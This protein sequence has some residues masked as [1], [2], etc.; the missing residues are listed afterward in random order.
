MAWWAGVPQRT[1]GGQ[2]LCTERPPVLWRHSFGRSTGLVQ[3][4]MRIPTRP[5]AGQQV[6][7]QS[8]ADIQKPK[9][10]FATVQSQE[11][12]FAILDAGVAAKKIPPQLMLAFKDFY[13]NYKSK[14]S[15]FLSLGVQLA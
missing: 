9:A 5:A 10:S 6:L 11:E 14:F 8:V 12:F 15:I 1:I 7:I 3:R 2:R 4:Q 13:N